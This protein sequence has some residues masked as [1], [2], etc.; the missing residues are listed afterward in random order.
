MSDYNPAFSNARTSSI[1]NPILNITEQKFYDI[2]LPDDRGGLL[3]NSWKAPSLTSSS[4]SVVDRKTARGI[5]TT[6]DFGNPLTLDTEQSDPKLLDK[7]IVVPQENVLDS[8]RSYTYNF[9]LAALSKEN[10]ADPISYRNDKKLNFVILK[11]GGKGS[12][13]KS[14]TSYSAA[15]QSVYNNLS[16]DPTATVESITAA[17]KNLDTA[18]SIDLTTEFNKSSP[19]RFDMYLDD[20]EIETL[21]TF[22]ANTDTTMA[23]G[24]KFDVIEP[25]SI[26][27]FIEAL[28]VGAVSAGYKSYIGASFLLKIKNHLLMLTIEDH[29]LTI[30]QKCEAP[31]V[32]I[33]RNSIFL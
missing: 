22:T 21:M 12:L 29:S 11:S 30:A 20:V 23:T 14:S 33:P 27:G 28:H 24:V 5:E 3:A 2:N 6:D 4:G 15:A 8:Y 31:R 9:T 18:N 19:G 25:Y 7:V 32:L 1:P 16:T 10:M 17:K 26:N 13:D